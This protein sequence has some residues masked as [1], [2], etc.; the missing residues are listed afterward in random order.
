MWTTRSCRFAALI[1]LLALFPAF[2][3]LGATR[4]CASPQQAE[5]EH[6]RKEGSDSDTQSPPAPCAVTDAASCT[7]I[8]LPG[9]VVAIEDTPTMTPV[10]MADDDSFPHT[11]FHNRVFHPP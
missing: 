7:S 1:G 9:A 4:H 3:G 6:E 11:I 5:H 8:T 10:R 2:T